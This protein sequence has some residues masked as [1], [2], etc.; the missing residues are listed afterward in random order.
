M[1]E[2]AQQE[3]IRVLKQDAN[4]CRIDAQDKQARG[5]ND[6]AAVLYERSLGWLDKA[7]GILDKGLSTPETMPIGPSDRPSDEQRAMCADRADCYGMRGGVLRRKHPEDLQEAL[8]EYLKGITDEQ[9][10]GQSTYCLSNSIVLP[11]LLGRESF[12]SRTIQDR[13]KKIIPMLEDAVQ[14][15]RSQSRWAWADL[16]QFYLLSGRLEDALRCY[17]HYK[18]AGAT[19]RDFDTTI[20]ILTKLSQSVGEDAGGFGRAIKRLGS[21][22]SS[23]TTSD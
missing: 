20:D 12:S 17:D 9:L 11:I 22:R 4:A 23:P 6:E 3:R 15:E 13:L 19:G 10:G 1:T 14:D 5:E 16:G 18:R 21:F 7:I 8:D 2:Y